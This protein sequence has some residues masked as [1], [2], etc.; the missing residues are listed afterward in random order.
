M[1][2]EKNHK[3]LTSQIVLPDCPK[4]GLASMKWAKI[5]P[6]TRGADNHPDRRAE[7]KSLVCNIC[8]RP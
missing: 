3:F 6:L 7:W 4:K 2:T 5:R 1:I 8:N